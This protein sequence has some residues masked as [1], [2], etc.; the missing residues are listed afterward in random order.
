M[1]FRLLSSAFQEGATI[2]RSHTCEGE[3]TSPPL[4]WSGV[5]AGALSFAIVCEDPDAPGGIW[6]H[7][8]IFNIPKECHELKSAI[9][10]KSHVDGM[11]QAVNSFQR[12][13]YGGPCPPKGH[14]R[15]H[16]RFRLFAL[17][18]GELAV[19]ANADC[20]TVARLA[21]KQSLGEVVLTGLYQ[22]S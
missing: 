9:P 14:G 2:P 18:T 13:G 4:G 7:W 15:H 21:H 10:G 3:D 19:P 8:G 11:R 1:T 6:Y 17:S 12:V 16:Y 22:R 5:P 20:A